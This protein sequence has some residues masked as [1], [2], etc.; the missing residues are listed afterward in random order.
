[1]YTTDIGKTQTAKSRSGKM[2]SEMRNGDAKRRVIREVAKQEK[3]L[4][5]TKIRNTIQIKLYT[6]F[7]IKKTHKITN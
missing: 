7:V 3:K 5:M 2:R 4:L 1:M 6:V